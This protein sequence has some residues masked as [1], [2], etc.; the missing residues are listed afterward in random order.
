MEPKCSSELFVKNLLCV[1]PSWH[2][3]LVR[4][5]KE[6]LSS[7]MS[8]ETY[9]CLE[10]LKAC[11]T[12]T[13]TELAHQLKV[14]KQQVTKLVDKLAEHQF[15]ERIGKEDDR[16]AVLIRLTPRAITYLDEY[17]LKNT[18]FIQALEGQLTEN[19]LEE[20]NEAVMTLGRIL[21]KLN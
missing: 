10:T 20:L 11:G 7:E 16:R 8:L 9:Y 21:P 3:R 13:M 6:K 5:F 18:A 19:E 4:P 14:P 2:T 15:I 12:A 17:Y 1:L